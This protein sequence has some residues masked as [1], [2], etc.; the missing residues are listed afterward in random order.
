MRSLRALSPRQLLVFGWLGFMTYAFPGYMSFDSVFQLRMSRSGYLIDGH[1]PFMAA[2]WRFVELFVAGPVGMLVIQTA[3]FLIGAYLVFRTVMSPQRAAIVATL[4]LWFPPVASVMAVIWKDSQMT[5]FLILGF[6][7]MLQ[8]RRR[9]HVLA[10]IAILIATMMRHNTLTMTGPILVFAFR[11]NPDYGWIKSTALAIV[12]WIAITVTA[13]AINSALTDEEQHFWHTNIALN[14]MTGTLRYAPEEIS[15]AEL[16]K[17]APGVKFMVPNVQAYVRNADLDHDYVTALWKT[18]FAV[19]VVP[20]TAAERAAVTAA[21]KRIVFGNLHAYC[22]YRW[23]IDRRL[24]GLS[25]EDEGSPVYNWFT[26]IQ[27]PYYTASK[28]DHDATGAHLQNLLREEIH[29]VAVSPIFSV[30]VY[31]LLVVLLLPFALRD[32]QVFGLLASAITSELALLVI[33]PTPDWRYSFWAIIA[34][35][36]SVILLVARRIRTDRPRSVS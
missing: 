32:R 29:V 1:P 16:A 26:D 8:D 14:D 7:L 19:F 20:R 4:V 30:K 22:A 17:L 10:L 5:G 18:T 27:D 21:W 2:L 28:I 11:W 12:A 34:V 36:F 33:V 35:V 31:L 23:E 24:L 25:D 15:D 9:D 6:G 3:A 13:G